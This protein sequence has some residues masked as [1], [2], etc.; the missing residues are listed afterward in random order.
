M[1]EGGRLEVGTLVASRYRVEAVLGRG[2][3][4]SVYRALDERS[5]EVV[6]LKALRVDLHDREEIVRRFER[7]ARAV[8]RIGHDGIAAVH[9]IG[10]DEGLRTHFI[11]QECLRG[12]DVAACLNELGSLAPLSAV[13]I[14]LPVMDALIAAHAL[15]IVHRDIKPENVFVHERED[16][17]VVPKV[18]DFGIA[19]VADERGRASRT[20]TGAVFG[21][22]WYMSP[23][24]AE[25]ST[26]VDAR[27]D[28]WSVGVMLYEML[29]GALPFGASDPN[30]VMAQIIYGRPTPLEDHLPGVPDDLRAVVHR[31]LERDLGRR[32]GSMQEFRDA[33]AACDVWRGMTPELAQA[34]LPHPCSFEGIDDIL[35]AEFREGPEAREPDAATPVGR[36]EVP[37]P[38]DLRPVIFSAAPAAAETEDEES[39]PTRPLPAK[40]HRR[41]PERA[42]TPPGVVG[43]S[44]ALTLLCAAVLAL[45]IARW[46]THVTSRSGAPAESAL[47]VAR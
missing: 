39:V 24:Q 7:E 21:T 8:A 14:A 6:A 12:A 32:Y 11:V 41:R 16:G 26:A 23:E 46:S 22:P 13:A 20:A 42:A 40:P 33:L 4:G 27:S 45:G 25:G 47:S 31:A 29:C 15:G 37:E 9:A 36:L 28:V 10:H 3:M 38:F 18:I 44:V 19:K 30:A 5:G 1:D 2:G 43:V 35:P 17:R 34:V